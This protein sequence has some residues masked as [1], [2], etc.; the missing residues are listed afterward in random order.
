MQIERRRVLVVSPH[1]DDVPLSLGESLLSGSLARA[2]SVSVRVVFGRTN[3]T[4][5][6]HPTR[7]R[8]WLVSAWRRA[9]ELAAALRFGY[10]FRAA[11]LEEA[12]LRTGTLDPASYRGDA[13]PADDPMVDRLVSMI[14]RW[15]GVSD[16]VLVPA[17][18][19]GHLDHRLVATAGVR[20][21]RGGVAE[22]AFYEDRPYTAYLGEEELESQL[23]ALGLE[24]EPRDVSGPISESTQRTVAR[25][26]RSQ[27]DG[28]FLDAQRRDRAHGARERIWVPR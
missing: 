3:W 14:R 21:H 25:I 13:D 9:E 12:I 15:S 17:G 2:S 16:V 20:C 28:Y 5:A 8:A 6:L 7:R 18:L 23:G 10:T 11:P 24:L 27:M 4:T 1:F 26:Y 22:V 19:G